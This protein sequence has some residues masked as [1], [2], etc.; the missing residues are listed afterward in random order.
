MRLSHHRPFTMAFHAL[1]GAGFLAATFLVRP[2]LP[3]NKNTDIDQICGRANQTV[4]SNS[5]QVESVLARISKKYFL[6][7]AGSTRA[8]CGVGRHSN[9][10]LALHNIRC[11][12]YCLQF[13]LSCPGKAALQGDS[14]NL[15]TS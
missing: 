15:E 9:H 4:S 3:D 1:I 14:L 8:V 12:V 6:L 13:W 10:C 5:T 11:L 2:F 7:L